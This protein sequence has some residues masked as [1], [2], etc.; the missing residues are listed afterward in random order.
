MKMP[1]LFSVVGVVGL[2]LASSGDETAD[3]LTPTSVLF[4]R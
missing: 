3:G 4:S 1:R 2:V